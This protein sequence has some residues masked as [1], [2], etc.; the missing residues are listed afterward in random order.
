MNADFLLHASSVLG[1]LF[2]AVINIMVQVILVKPE[3][4]LVVKL[5]PKVELKVSEV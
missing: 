4:C 2:K 5:H 3:F 1:L